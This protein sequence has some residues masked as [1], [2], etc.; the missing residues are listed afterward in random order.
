[1]T[2]PFT[3]TPFPFATASPWDRI[4]LGGIA[5]SGLARVKGA[6]RARKVDVPKKSGGDGAYVIIKRRE[7]AEPV[8]TLIGWTEGHLAEMDRIADR[9]FPNERTERHN[10]VAVEHPELLFHD[11]DEIFV[12]ELEGPTPQDDGTFELTLRAHQWRP[13]PPRNTAR[14]ASAVAPVETRPI[15]FQGVPPATPTPPSQT[16]TPRRRP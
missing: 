2:T 11:I 9:V 14:R 1:M 10:A 16:A 15:A 13:A 12:H 8:I 6:K 3:P 7:L 5:F 4:T